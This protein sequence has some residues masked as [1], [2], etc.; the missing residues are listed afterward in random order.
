M[1]SRPTT[2]MWPE[3]VLEVPAISDDEPFS[4]L[5]EKLSFY[6]AEAVE[7]PYTFEELRSIP[8][9]IVL[10][11]LIKYLSDEIHHPAIVSAL[12]ALKTHFSA[13]DSDDDRGVN[14]ARGYACE[15][16][17]WRFVTHLSEREA[18]E[19]LLYEL[20]PLGP[21]TPHEQ[22]PE[23]GTLARTNGQRASNV[24]N[25]DTPLLDEFN[26]TNGHRRL[27]TDS[28]TEVTAAAQGDEFTNQFVNLS[29]L[30]IAAVSGSK[31]FLS[32]RVI[33]RIIDGIWRGDIVFWETLRFDSVKEAK[34]YNRRRADPFCR[35]RVPRY[36]K[37][38]ETL[39]FATFLLLYYAVL[40]QRSYTHI[41][42]AEILLYIWIAGFAYDEFG[43]IQ[44][45]GQ[46][47]FYTTDFWFVWDLGI[48]AF[49]AAFLVLRIVGLSIHS[50]DLVD[51]AFDI[52]A[53]EALLLIPRIFSL[54]SL[55]PY[56]GTL[57]PCL[58]E[59]T[60]DFCKFLSL[61][62]ILYLGFLT[63]FTLLARDQIKPNEMSWILIKVFFGSSYLGFD[64]AQEISPLFGPPV[65]LIFVALT[66]IL[67]ITSL[68]SLLSNSLTKVLD[69]ARDEYLY[70]YSVY[71][72]EASTSNRLTYYLPPLNLIALL[73][74][75]LRLVL[76]AERLRSARIVLLKGTHFP[77][78]AAIWAYEHGQDYWMSRAQAPSTSLSMGG[79]ETS[80]SKKRPPLK[81]SLNS[82]RPLAAA[83]GVQASLD[84]HLGGSPARY[85]P[86][87]ATGTSD[88]DAQLRSL[89]IHL[90]SQVEQLTAM[91]G[92]LQGQQGTTPSDAE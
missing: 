70:I 78:V 66:N 37:T 80:P 42:P 10:S 57:I 24:A 58:K 89:V 68:I 30:E 9:G 83:T 5:V 31:K 86:H 64:V 15:I 54:L 38:F 21:A 22:D 13:L 14:E 40:V 34:R 90:N 85:R 20:P 11:P 56:F 44:D 55:N 36:L 48:V 19:F 62:V 60:K 43:E 91:V 39:F 79:P 75:P 52:L 74:R 27:G 72:L 69:H 67:L 32:Q 82:P 87:T 18:I 12:L 17:A 81:S 6:F 49:G 61:V 92:Q 47:S 16:V 51:M 73:L 25:E 26:R 29:A 3:H 46:T 28:V 71:V 23:S 8:K 84:G 53:L 50:S 2:P 45:A 41:T 59:M 35:L 76:P 1:A 63:T 7:A 65:M 88:G 4:D 77:F 33:Q